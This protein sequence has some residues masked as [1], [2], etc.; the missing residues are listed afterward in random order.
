MDLFNFQVMIILKIATINRKMFGLLEYFIG[1][2]PGCSKQGEDNPGLVQ[3]FN[4]DM[5]A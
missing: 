5:K 3:N 2:G 1:S 4:S